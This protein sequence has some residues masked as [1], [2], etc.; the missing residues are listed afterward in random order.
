MKDGGGGLRSWLGVGPPGEN[1]FSL[2]NIEE[3]AEDE[4]G[5]G[6]LEDP[7]GLAE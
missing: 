7:R 5:S 4:E 3:E 2:S 6:V 1:D